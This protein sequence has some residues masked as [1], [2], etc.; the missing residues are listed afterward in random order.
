[1]VLLCHVRMDGAQLS[2][3]VLSILLLGNWGVDIFLLVPGIGM[4]Y[5][6][7]H[8]YSLLYK[9]LSSS[10]EYLNLGVLLVIVMIIYIC[11]VGDNT[12]VNTI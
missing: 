10:Y 6:I 12:I 9:L 3:V 4:Y 8:Y 1:M 7:I 11:S 5:S 2:D